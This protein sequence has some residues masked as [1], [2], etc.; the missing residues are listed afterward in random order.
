M[1]TRNQTRPGCEIVWVLLVGRAAPNRSLKLRDIFEIGLGG[2]VIGRSAEKV[3]PGSSTRRK[4]GER[5]DPRTRLLKVLSDLGRKAEHPRDPRHAC[6][7]DPLPP[8]DLNLISGL[9]RLEASPPLQGPPREI[10]HPRCPRFPGRRRR[11]SRSR[12]GALN[13]LRRHL[14]RTLLPASAVQDNLGWSRQL[15]GLQLTTGKMR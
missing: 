6:P 5:P 10:D 9:P 11:R 7:G 12:H 2:Y 4:R 1:G 14:R 13:P 15:S 3:P 8:G